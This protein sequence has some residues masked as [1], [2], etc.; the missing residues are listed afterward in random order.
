MFGPS[1][2]LPTFLL[3]YFIT[4]FF[5]LHERLKRDYKTR[6]RTSICYSTCSIKIFIVHCEGNKIE[7]KGDLYKGLP[8][9]WWSWNLKVVLFWNDFIHSIRLI[10]MEFFVSI[11]DLGL[12]IVCRSKVTYWRKK[13]KILGLGSSCPIVRN[14]LCIWNLFT[15]VIAFTKADCDH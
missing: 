9:T 5:K 12:P 13:T 15:I 3:F 7:K 6:K 11:I 10:I 4:L 14:R 2:I 1:M 8:T